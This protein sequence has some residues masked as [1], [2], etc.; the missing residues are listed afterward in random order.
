MAFFI[1]GGWFLFLILVGILI[2]KDA[3]HREREERQQVREANWRAGERR[4]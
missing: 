1:L 3:N 4:R 2:Y